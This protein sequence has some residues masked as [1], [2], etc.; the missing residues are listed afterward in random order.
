M[1]NSLDV[2]LKNQIGN[3]KYIVEFLISVQVSFPHGIAA[4]KFIVPAVQSA[5]LSQCTSPENS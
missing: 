2:Y 3:E 1:K 4:R 5:D